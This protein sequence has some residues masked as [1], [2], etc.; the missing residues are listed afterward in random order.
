[1]SRPLRPC[2]GLGRVLGH[3]YRARFDS[4]IPPGL[5]GKG[6]FPQHIEAS[7]TKVY[8]GDICTRCGSRLDAAVSK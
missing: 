1:M 8:R 5:S 3:K 6:L 7:R 2:Q 4:H